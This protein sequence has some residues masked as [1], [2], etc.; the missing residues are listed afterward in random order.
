MLSGARPGNYDRIRCYRFLLSGDLA[1]SADRAGDVRISGMKQT[2]AM[3]QTFMLGDRH[4][5]AGLHVS[6]RCPCGPEPDH[7][8]SGQ[9]HS[10]S[11][12]W[13][14]GQFRRRHPV[15][16]E[17]HHAARQCDGIA[18]WR[19]PLQYRHPEHP[20]LLAGLFQVSYCCQR[21]P[22]EQRVRGAH[23]RQPLCQGSRAG[24]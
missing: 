11:G 13:R 3:K 9:H 18:H 22:S 21:P 7:Y 15:E 6:R 17:H 16:R 1:V 24:Q 19:H 2:S 4:S 10:E 23:Q 5:W 12:D 20:H 14:N 8:S